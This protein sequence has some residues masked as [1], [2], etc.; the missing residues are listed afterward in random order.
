LFRARYGIA[1]AQLQL[2]QVW[3]QRSRV[4]VTWSLTARPVARLRC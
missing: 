1:W 3:D 2:G 4:P